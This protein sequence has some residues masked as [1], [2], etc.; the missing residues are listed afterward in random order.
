M[1]RNQKNEFGEKVVEN[2][3]GYA[4]MVGAVF[5]LGGAYA[6]GSHIY[7]SLTKDKEP[8]P[9]VKSVDVSENYRLNK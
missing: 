3:M 4:A 6:L 5:A 7:D 2:L 9:I 1:R 8:T